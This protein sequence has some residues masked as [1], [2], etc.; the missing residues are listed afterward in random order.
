MTRKND[1]ILPRT[2]GETET[3]LAA[4]LDGI[5]TQMPADATWTIAGVS[6]NKRNLEKEVAGHLATFTAPRETE[7]AFHRATKERDARAPVT[8]GFLAD[9]LVALENQLGRQ[10]DA[11]E[12]FGFRAR[13]KPAPRT[14]EEK[15]AQVALTLQTK[16]KNGTIGPRAEEKKPA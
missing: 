14:A 13:R 8:A 9:M 10:S 3:C 4:L 16:A 11:L 2:V 6:F 7:A 12:D 5:K 1:K 15:A